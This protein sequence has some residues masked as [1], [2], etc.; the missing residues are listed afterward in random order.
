[1]AS[2][3]LS[4]YNS[5]LAT[6]PLRGFRFVASFT[7]AGGS[8][9]FSTK[10]VDGTSGAAP[11]SGL[12]SGWVGGFTNVTGLRINTQNITYR[13]GG[14]NT[15]VHQMPGMTTFDPVAFTRGVLYGND[16]ALTWMRGLF[17]AAAGSGLN[18]A[19]GANRNFRVDITIQVNDHPNT[20][21]SNDVPKM[22]FKIHNAFI[23][24]LSY[25][26]LDATTGSI[27]FESM[28]LVHEG[29]SVFFV[30]KNGKPVEPGLTA[31][32]F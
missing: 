9:T 32:S 11:T 3:T 12:S 16:Q 19:G 1:M 27:L 30:D 23:T 8:T 25:T 22:A 2:S 21:A 28:T 18:P 4:T 31:D 20:D 6:D 17:A 29:L 24:G 15:T 5:S 13:E 26:D 7:P 10:I 14:Y